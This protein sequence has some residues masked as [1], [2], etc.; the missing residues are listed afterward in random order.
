MTQHPVDSLSENSH[1]RQI[2]DTITD[3]WMRDEILK[4]SSITVTLILFYISK[5]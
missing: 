5:W 4:Y 1:Q 2:S 3:I